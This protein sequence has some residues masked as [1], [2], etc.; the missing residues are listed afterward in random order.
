MAKI[1]DVQSPDYTEMGVTLAGTKAAGAF[2]TLNEVNGFYMVGGVAT[3]K[4]TF[5]TKARKVKC[6]KKTGVVTAPG[7]A[8][9]YITGTVTNVASGAI[10][11]G[12]FIEDAA[13]AVA[14]TL[15]DF[16]GMLAFAKA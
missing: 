8:A 12:S 14:E 10:L 11:I 13:T 15:I 1:F 16:D 7:E 9:Y 5:V 2:D 6:V 4:V 3:E